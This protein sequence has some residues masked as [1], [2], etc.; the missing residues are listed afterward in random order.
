VRGGVLPADVRRLHQLHAQPGLSP[1][2]EPLVGA[3]RGRGLQRMLVG[4]EDGH[5][6]SSE[7]GTFGLLRH[8]VAMPLS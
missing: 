5:K 1:G 2:R 6:N 3:V 8:C 7:P 4:R